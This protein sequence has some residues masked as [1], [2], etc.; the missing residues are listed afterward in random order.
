MKS[1]TYYMSNS[2]VNSGVL[3]AVINEFPAFIR[4]EIIELNCYK[5]EV[6]ARSEDWGAINEK[7]SAVSLA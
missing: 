4:K 1:K 3:S 5:V 2:A 7:L 6:T